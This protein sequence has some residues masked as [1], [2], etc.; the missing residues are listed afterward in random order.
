MSTFRTT[1]A[2]VNN[3]VTKTLSTSVDAMDLLS[4]YVSNKKIEQ[5]KKGKLTLLANVTEHRAECTA[6]I[7]KSLDKLKEI[8]PSTLSWIDEQLSG[9]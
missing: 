6:R 2:A 7:D 1:I 9:M 5:E 8:S 4:N 3:T